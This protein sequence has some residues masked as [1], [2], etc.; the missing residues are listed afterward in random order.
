MGLVKRYD[1][2]TRWE[3]GV[4]GEGRDLCRDEDARRVQDEPPVVTRPED[5]EAL[6][7]AIV[8]VIDDAKERGVQDEG[9]L[10]RFF[11]KSDGLPNV[12]ELEK[13]LGYSITAAER[14][15]AVEFIEERDTAPDA[16]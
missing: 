1:D 4:P 11:N 2:P 15:A 3:G 14:N 7:A 16:D 8:K 6:Q 13:A 5:E 12:A 9:I 10:K